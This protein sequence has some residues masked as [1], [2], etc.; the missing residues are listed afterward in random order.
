[1]VAATSTALEISRFHGM[2]ICLSLDRDQPAVT[3]QSADQEW[4]AEIGITD[5]AVIAGELQTLDRLSIQEWLT[6]HRDDL[7]QAWERCA[8]GHDPDPIEALPDDWPIGGP[9]PTRAI[10]VKPLEGYRL[11]IEW[12][13]GSVGELDLANLAGHPAFAAWSDQGVFES[14]RIAG[15]HLT[16]GKEMEICAW[17]EC[18]PTL[19]NSSQKQ[20]DG[21]KE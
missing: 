21:A 18:W 12:E 7:L 14:V 5:S 3:V 20:P 2:V 15:S 9:S 4:R 6:L 11:R 8:E 1:M 16:W 17:L 13:D 19:G 10:S